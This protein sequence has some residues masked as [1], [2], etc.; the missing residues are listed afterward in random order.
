LCQDTLSCRC[1]STCLFSA[2]VFAC[3]RSNGPPGSAQTNLDPQT[4]GW[5][6]LALCAHMHTIASINR[7][8]V[9]VGIIQLTSMQQHAC[10]RW[11]ASSMNAIVRRLLPKVNQY[12]AESN[13]LMRRRRHLVV[14]C[15][16]WCLT[17]AAY[18]ARARPL[19][20]MWQ[21]WV[22]CGPAIHCCAHG[23]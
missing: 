16:I 12:G 20:F 11:S 8:A 4:D 7:F 6:T 19:R 1:M 23:S 18:S 15:P 21:S 17:T 5:T 2:A 13:G 3:K 14:S 10:L 9:R 22:A